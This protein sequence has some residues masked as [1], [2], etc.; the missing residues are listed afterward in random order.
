MV[1]ISFLEAFGINEIAHLLF[2]LVP[3]TRHV[4]GDRGSNW[5][6]DE[7]SYGYVETS[8]GN[9]HM[10]SKRGAVWTRAHHQKKKPEPE[11]SKMISQ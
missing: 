10:P 6:I 5:A 4:E 3:T 2:I 8:T 1:K 9:I 7:Y 11:D